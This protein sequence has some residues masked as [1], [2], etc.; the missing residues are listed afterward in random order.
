M[1]AIAETI[2]SQL[3]YAVGELGWNKQR[4]KFL[5]ILWSAFLPISLF[6]VLLIVGL[7]AFLVNLWLVGRSF[8]RLRSSKTVIHLCEKGLLD[9][10]GEPTVLRY[11]QIAELYT[12]IDQAKVGP[13]F[14]RYGVKMQNGRQMQFGIEVANPKALGNALQE[15][16]VIAQ[17]PQRLSEVEKGAEIGFNRLSLSRH[18]LSLG[19]KQLTWSEFD[20]AKIVTL[21]GYK[22]SQSVFLDIYAKGQTH[23]WGRFQRDRFPNL[24]LFFAL[25]E[26]LCCNNLPN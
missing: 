17:L 22:S 9:T 8:R 15:G 18:G 6:S 23:F 11:A 16:M 13:V 24:A 2:S 4:A 25:V 12:G 14:Y 5:L 1:S 21:K 20:Q 7:P 19:K 3:G 26:Q 10:R